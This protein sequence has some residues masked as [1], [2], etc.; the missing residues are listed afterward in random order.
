MDFESSGLSREEIRK[1]R[2]KKERMQAI[3]ILAFVILV[4]A[5]VIGA[6]VFVLVRVFSG[7]D[8]KTESAQVDAVAT[9]SVVSETQESALP[10]P[11]EVQEE[12]GTGEAVEP[13]TESV[14]I[15]ESDEDAVEEQEEV[16]VMP[17]LFDEQDNEALEELVS[18]KLSS[19]TLEQK[20]AELF[21]VKPNQLLG[22]E[23]D[24]TIVGSEFGEKIKTYP[25]GGILLDDSNMS[26]D[27]DFTALIS[28]IQT[29]SSEDIFVGIAHD[30][31][32]TSP[33]ITGGLTENVIS[34]YQEIG[35]TLGTSGAYSA[36]ISSG[37]MLKEYDIN[38]N[39]AP[40]V[41][42]SLT[43]GS[44]AQKEGFG[45]D[46]E[47]TAELGKNYIKGL[48][49]QG[50]FT[51]V[52]HFPSYGDVTQDGD[53]GQVVSQR[54]KEDLAGEYA[55]YIEAI[56]AGADFVVVSHVSLPQVRGDKRPASL[57]KEVITDIIRTE[58]E[59][60]GIVITDFMNKS[61]MYQKY[62][63]AEAA[64]GAIEAG[65]DMI[66]A[67]KNFLKSYNGILDAVNDGTLTEERIDESV[68]RIYRVKYESR[69]TN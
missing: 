43:Q 62:T 26:A 47:T 2:R 15:E 27:A 46:M 49:D 40:N 59:Y 18:Q 45:A 17:G 48:S 37:G 31:G 53:G 68:R 20:I 38:V 69:V 11:E 6:V 65:A 56:D 8:K 54:T 30:G 16:D 25:V 29:Y 35:E 3:V 24:V 39:F 61:C 13:E 41:D 57:S 14:D 42:V 5:L 7:P 66:L 21:F 28:N 12:D 19:M 10:E 52:K 9:E 4:I 55:P 58:W 64:V 50:I 33:L 67:P 34:S 51:A 63:Y 44:V 23:S 1:R 36:G 22:N 60:D 32:E